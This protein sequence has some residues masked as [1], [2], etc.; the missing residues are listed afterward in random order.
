[1]AR[2]SSKP[3][4]SSKKTTVSRP[5]QIV[6]TIRRS[7]YYLKLVLI[8]IFIFLLG[9][10]TAYRFFERRPIHSPESDLPANKL[11]LTNQVIVTPSP[12]SA[13]QLSVANEQ[14]TLALK[15]KPAVPAHQYTV[16]IGDSL[17]TIAEQVTK[18]P[19]Q[20]EKIY[21]LNQ[22]K[23]G[24]NPNHIEPGMVLTLGS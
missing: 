5:K 21:Q 7:N 3:I 16:Q 1:M 6:R 14:L 12:T 10:F 17:W 11:A 4:R 13:D 18:D 8:A 22:S 15:K 9:V 24:R 23:I 19:Y 2:H 20:W